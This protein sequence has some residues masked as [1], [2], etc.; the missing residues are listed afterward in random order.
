MKIKQLIPSFLLLSGV[1]VGTS[2][3][4]STV[5]AADSASEMVS[6]ANKKVLVGYWH[7]WASKGKD[8]Y[9]QG[10]SANIS[11]SEVNKAYNVVPVSFMKSDGL[12]RIP[13]FAPYNKTDAAFRQDVAS[14]NSQGRAVLLALGGADA[15]IQLQKGDEQAFAD[16]IIRQVET[17]GFDGLDIDL[18]QSAITAGDNQTVIPTALKMVKDYYKTQGKNFIITMAPE[19]PYL[20]P[21]GAYEKYITSLNGYYD[22]IAP[23]LYNQGG[24]G[25]W[26][27]EINKWIPQSNDALKYEFLYYMSDSM[28]HGTRTFL[29][30]PN[31]KLVLGLPANVDGAGSGYVIDPTAVYKALDQLAKDGNPIKGL[32]TWSANWDIGTNASGVSYNN[33]FATRYTRILQ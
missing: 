28:I 14:L 3:A 20:K 23:Q 11:L 22:Y 21:S 32:M 5:E 10:T 33:E 30:I 16:E 25:V 8:G 17:Y 6:V 1:I 9:K 13:T 19:F 18:E 26:V 29:K 15:H 12:S 2:L 31:D 4:T 7:N 24:D 27:D